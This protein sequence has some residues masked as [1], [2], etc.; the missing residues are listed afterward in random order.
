MEG[1][2]LSVSS[3]KPSEKCSFRCRL[4][5]EGKE[6]VKCR[7][8]TR[9]L[10]PVW[11]SLSRAGK[12]S[13][14]WKQGNIS[15]PV[16]TG[17][18]RGS[19]TARQAGDVGLVGGAAKVGAPASS[20][21]G[22]QSRPGR[23]SPG[24]RVLKPAWRTSLVRGCRDGSGWVRSL[25]KHWVLRFKSEQADKDPVFMGRMGDNR[26]LSEARGW[27]RWQGKGPG[28]LL[29][30]RRWSRAPCSESQEEGMLGWG[31]VL[32]PSSLWGQAEW[33]SGWQR[34]AQADGASPW[35]LC[36]GLGTCFPRAER[37]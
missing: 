14:G 13:V 24:G 30:G 28:E 16:V 4:R 5:G 33:P 31:S 32:V 21:R 11:E 37:C 20:H 2:D 7:S 18:V 25:P 1:G 22:T 9:K 8:Q 36:S 3:S 34:V 35:G 27:D 12:G 26:N 29:S 15:A 6:Q 10:G 19:E 17:E 23:G